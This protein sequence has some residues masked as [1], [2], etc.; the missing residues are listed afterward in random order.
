[1]L[2]KIFPEAIKDMSV[3]TFQLTHCC[4]IRKNSARCEAPTSKSYNQ[5]PK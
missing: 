2:C 4:V 1:M 3:E 5:V